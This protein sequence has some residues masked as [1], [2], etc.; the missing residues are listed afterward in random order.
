MEP[1]IGSITDGAHQ[2]KESLLAEVKNIPN[3][4]LGHSV[5]SGL[6]SRIDLFEKLKKEGI[7]KLPSRKQ[8]MEVQPGEIFKVYE[9]RERYFIK[10]NTKEEDGYVMLREY[11]GGKGFQST[12]LGQPDK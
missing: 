11:M 6:N 10:D 8:I 9:N 12:W 1:F 7:L 2:T 4:M 5:I 3:E